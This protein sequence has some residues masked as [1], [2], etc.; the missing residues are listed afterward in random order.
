M[1]DVGLALAATKH[2]SA[3]RRARRRCSRSLSIESISGKQLTSSPNT[4]SPRAARQT[5]ARRVRRTAPGRR[6][7]SCRNDGEPRRQRRPVVL[8]SPYPYDYP[9]NAATGTAGASLQES[10][11]VTR[12][13]F[14]NTGSEASPGCRRSHHQQQLSSSGERRL[15]DEQRQI[16]D[17]DWRVACFVLLVH[18]RRRRVILLRPAAYQNIAQM[19]PLATGAYGRAGSRW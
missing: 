12:S 8:A 1:N 18:L 17:A 14:V 6:C 15:V 2:R 10:P 19:P 9:S 13:A 4:N 3:A 7:P 11:R 16:E 5:R